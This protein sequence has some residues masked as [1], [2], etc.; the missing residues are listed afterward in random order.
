MKTCTLCKTEK[1]FEEFSKRKDQKD[2]LH[3]WCRPC[4]KIK[5]AESYQKNRDKALAAM[6]EYRK[7]NP[8]K[9]AAAKKAAYQKKPEHY[10]AKHRERY[11]ADPEPFI[12]RSGARYESKRE[13]ILAYGKEYRELNREKIRVRA[14]AYREKNREKLNARQIERQRANRESFNAYQL[15]YRLN[16]YKTDPLYALQ[17]TCRRRILC[18]MQK[19]GYKKSTK[20]EALLGCS[21]EEFKAFLEAKFLP[22]MTWENRGKFGW[23]IDHVVPLSSAKDRDEMEKLCHYTNMQP[24]WAKDNHAKGAKMLHELTPEQAEKW[25]TG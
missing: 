2:G 4:L 22:G 1:P 25:R 11:L 18:A 21:F 17:M 10:K 6:A 16:R 15:Q 20:T 24:L 3:F 19:G 23:H 7:A 9:V 13:Q 14:A 5:K 8:E 12:A